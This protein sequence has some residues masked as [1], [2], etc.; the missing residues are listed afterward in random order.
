MAIAFAAMAW[1][2]GARLIAGIPPPWGYV[3]AAI[4]A[5]LAFLAGLIG[6]LVGDHDQSQP[7]GQALGWE[8]HPYVDGCGDYPPLHPVGGGDPGPHIG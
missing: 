1:T 4:L 5:L 8:I 3:V 6:Y 2:A 7:R